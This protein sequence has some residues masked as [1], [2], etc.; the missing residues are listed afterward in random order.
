MRREPIDYNNPLGISKREWTMVLGVNLALLLTVYAVAVTCTLL[1]NDFFLLK[2]SNPY[3]DN[4]ENTLRSW[5][6][7]ALVQIAFATVEEM[8][9]LTFVAFRKPKWWWP[10][11]F[12]AIRVVN[13]VLWFN[14]YG[15][16]PTWSSMIINIG[17]LLAF[18][19]AEKKKALKPLARL[20][21]VVALSLVLNGAI[22][23]F[24]TSLFEIHHA[25]TNIF[26]FYLNLE[27]YLALS[28]VLGLLA[29]VIPWDKTKGDQQW[30]TTFHAGGS[31]PI[32]MTKSLKNLPTN[33]CFT[34]AQKRRIRRLKTRTFIV[35]TM[36]LVFISFFPFLIGKP[37][38]FSLAYVSFCLTRLVLGF[39][40]SL[41]FK[42]ELAC[43]VTATFVF[44]LV[45]LLTPNVEASIISS[46]LYGSGVALGFRL[47]WELHD[48]MMYRRASKTDRYAMLYVAFKGRLDDRHI[49][50]VMR[51]KGHA[52]DEEIRMVQMYMGKDKVEYIADKLSYAKITVEKRLTDIAS[53][54]YKNR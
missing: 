1:G 38:E 35:Q 21:I 10:V 20:G 11:S 40:R 52:D 23:F 9:M 12:F 7:F 51:L 37:V 18:V 5:N 30:E 13:N 2:V 6:I 43:I 48:L 50:G 24:R 34:E 54:L 3:L 26:V 41:H 32:S 53:D 29:M 22:N 44:W 19:I 42:S 17:F 28:L 39:S 49:R 27:Y 8:I 47:Y 36:A 4:L 15:S 25:Y 33:G 45:T 16:V 31:S 46:L 14:L